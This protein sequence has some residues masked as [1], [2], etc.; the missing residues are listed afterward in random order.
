VQSVSEGPWPVP[1]DHRVEVVVA[2]TDALL[3]DACAEVLGERSRILNAIDASTAVVV[4]SERSFH[5]LGWMSA[6]AARGQGVKEGLLRSV[7]ERRYLPRIPVVCTS[8]VGQVHWMPSVE[9]VSDPDDI[10]H[11]QVARLCSARVIYSHDRHLRSPGFAPR[12]RQI[13]V[14]RITALG[15]VTEGRQVE[16]GAG[17]A[18]GAVGL[19]ADRL[20]TG[21]AAGLGSRKGTLWALVT[22]AGIATAVS[23]WRADARRTRLHAAFEPWAAHL[24]GVLQRS[25]D[26]N[27]DLREGSFVVTPDRSRLEIGV[28]TLLVRNGGLTATEITNELAL[29]PGRRSEVL[30]LLRSHPAFES[31]ERSRWS[32]GRTRQALET[33]PLTR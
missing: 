9:D 24:G 22:A 20:I 17:F 15:H 4:M 28:A 1:V 12:T 32:L 18:L 8:S 6:K 10:P 3:G 29:R 16:T 5:E 23:T 2:D 21:A 19:G 14:Q 27:R 11:V 26:A 30:A 25:T 31:R 7:I 33:W 13:Y